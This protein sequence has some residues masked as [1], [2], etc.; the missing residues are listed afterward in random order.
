[1]MDRQRVQG[2]LKKT[3]GTLKEKAGEALGDR[4]LESE[5]KAE[6]SEGHLRSGVGKA[7]DAVREVIHKEK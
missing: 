1:M 4:N 2:G 3:T 7:I 6:K 5:G